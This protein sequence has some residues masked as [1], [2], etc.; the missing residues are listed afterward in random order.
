MDTAVADLKRKRHLT[1]PTKFR[2]SHASDKEVAGLQK[3]RR[4][5]EGKEDKRKKEIATRENMDYLIH[6]LDLVPS[7][8][9]LFLDNY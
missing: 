2:D 3:K 1:V 4:K 7:E 8:C 5:L 6:N 9:T